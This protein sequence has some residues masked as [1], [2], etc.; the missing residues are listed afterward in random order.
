MMRILIFGLL[1]LPFWCSGQTT[2]RTSKLATSKYAGVYSFGTDIE[3]SSVGTILIYPETDTTVLFYINLNR[4]AP[5]YNMG[6]LYERVRITNGEGKF[7]T[8]FDFA[9]KGCRWTFKFLKNSLLIK[10][11][12]DQDEC[13][14]GAY[15]FADG[16]FKQISDK[17]LEH[18]ENMEGRK[19]FFKTT[20]PED[21][22]K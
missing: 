22:N 8:K 11:V 21:Y 3:K 5:S 4:G 19:V 16:D 12:G 7:Y 6:S 2:P 1:C 13:G 18:F 15:V 20:S 9:D 17:T 14:F 10:T